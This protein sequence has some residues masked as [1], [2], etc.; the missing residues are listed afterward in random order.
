MTPRTTLPDTMGQVHMNSQRLWQNTKDLYK[1]RLGISTE[2]EGDT[3]SY[4][5]PTNDLQLTDTD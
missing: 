5:L 2:G 3:G 1:F 4:P